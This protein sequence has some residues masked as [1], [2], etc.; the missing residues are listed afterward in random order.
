VDLDLR[1]VNVLIG[2]Q[3]TGK[4][5]VAKVLDMI[6]TV[7]NEAPNEFKRKFLEKLETS[8]IKNYFNNDTYIYFDNSTFNVEIKELDVIFSNKKQIEGK[9]TNLSYFIPSFRDAYILLRESYPAILNAKAILPSLLNLFGQIFNNKR[10][11]YRKFDFR[12]V[13]NVEYEYVNGNDIIILEDG[14]QITFEE[15]SSAIN[16][17]VPMLVVFDGIINEMSDDS[18]RILYRKNCPFITIEESELN[19][20]PLT[21]KKLVEH[22]I[23]KLKFKDYLKSNEYYCNLVLTTHSPYILSSLNNL[24]FA[25]KTGIE[26][27]EEVN[28]IIPS[29]YWLNPKDVSAYRLNEYGISEEIID[30]EG[31]IKTSKIDEASTILNTEFNKVF[32]L[33]FSVAK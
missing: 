11:E 20:Y 24:M 9:N 10:K 30:K 8:E 23:E 25:Y 22:L 19:C 17:V 2:D 16:S 1:K 27:F 13:I 4:S 18:F 32:D 21:Q 15:S 6:K 3:G 31:L 28:K 5:T 12:K 14:K 33:E 26:H 7:G 29:K